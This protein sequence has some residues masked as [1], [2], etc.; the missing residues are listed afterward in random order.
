MNASDSGIC[1]QSLHIRFSESGS[2]V[3]FYL[4]Y[5]GLVWTQNSAPA[6]SQPAAME[7]SPPDIH[8]QYESLIVGAADT[9]LGTIRPGDNSFFFYFDPVTPVLTTHW[10]LIACRSC[11]GA[12]TLGGATITQLNTV[13]EPSSVLLL[14]S[15]IVM[16]GRSTWRRAQRR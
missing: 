5:A 2:L 1:T 10:A 3:D 8:G 4:T 12:N 16:L 6:F 13:P 14:A 7:Y 11:A 9:G 15:G